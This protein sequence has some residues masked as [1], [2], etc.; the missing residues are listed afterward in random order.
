MRLMFLSAACAAMALAACAPTQT[1]YGPA[2]AGQRAVGYSDLR[3]EDARWR[4][5]FNAGPDLTT[6]EAERL[7]LRRAAELVTENGYDWFEVTD[8]RWGTEGGQ[9][10][11]VRVGG[12]VGQT[13]GSGGFRASGVGLG[14]GFSP[15]QERRT[16]VT[17]E[18]FAFRGELPADRGDVYDARS[19]L[20]SVY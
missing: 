12:S 8:R 2:A 7:A 19:I 18:V 14:V 13:F 5:S 3:I 20:S 10:S 4:V 9:S 1:V 6:A 15:G 11:P 17:L 16:G